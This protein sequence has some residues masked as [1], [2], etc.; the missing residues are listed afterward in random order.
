MDKNGY[1]EYGVMLGFVKLPDGEERQVSMY[2]HINELIE[3][4]YQIEIFLDPTQI[5]AMES[6]ERI[7]ML[8]FSDG[9]GSHVTM[10]PVTQASAFLATP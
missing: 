9:L 8:Y 4:A 3:V 7:D 2:G 5:H 1:S 6:G 10:Q